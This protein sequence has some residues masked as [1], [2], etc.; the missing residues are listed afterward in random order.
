M[1]VAL[2]Y[3][4]DNFD[5]P[6]MYVSMFRNYN[7]EAAAYLNTNYNL[8]GVPT[9]YFDGGVEVVAGAVSWTPLMDVT[10]L[11]CTRGAPGFGFSVELNHVDST[12]Y[13]I[14]VNIKHGN[15]RP[16]VLSEIA[17]VDF[18]LYTDEH[19]F[20]VATV[21]PEG[22]P[23]WYRF[24]WGDET[25][26]GWLGPYAS[27]DTCTASHIWSV[28]DSYDIQVVARDDWFHLSDTAHKTVSLWEFFHG[29]AN[30]DLM[31]NI[32]DVIY[33][34]QFLYYEGP[35]PTPYAAGD[36]DGNVVVN[37]VDLSY[38]INYLYFD[39]PPPV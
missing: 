20:S 12:L 5:I 15:E 18:G 17:G 6:F 27:G 19:S 32:L 22:G 35:Y 29:D 8:W 26:S 9:C 13:E 33:L 31:V 4:I 21:D 14:Q 10:N 24:K 2:Q 23:L 30:G 39:G 3:I 36:V 28:E 25:G 34:I 16:A 7:S 38:L 11:V 37:I 1:A